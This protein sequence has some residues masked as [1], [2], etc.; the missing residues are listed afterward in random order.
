LRRCGC[1]ALLACCLTASVSCCTGAPATCTAWPGCRGS[2][3]RAPYAAPS[4]A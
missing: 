4:S 3:G 2:W 1:R